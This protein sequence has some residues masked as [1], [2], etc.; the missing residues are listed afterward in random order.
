MIDG[1]ILVLAAQISFALAEL[2]RGE[3][4]EAI[5]ATF[6]HINHLNSLIYLSA[7]PAVDSKADS[8]PEPNVI[9]SRLFHIY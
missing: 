4:L 1:T 9:G 3:I 6:S 5:H 7:F 8:N 2:Y